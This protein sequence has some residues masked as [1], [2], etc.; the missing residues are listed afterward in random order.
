MQSISQPAPSYEIMHPSEMG[1]SEGAPN[2]GAILLEEITHRINNDIASTIAFIELTAARS[3]NEDVKLALAEVAQ[4]IHEFANVQR[5]LRVPNGNH[6][7]NA[8]EYLRRLCRSISLANLQYRDIELLFCETPVELGALSCWRMGMIVS[9]LITN[10]ARH[11]FIGR[12]GQI[13]VEL[14]CRSDRV[15][16]T[17]SDTGRASEDARPGHG[18]R[19]VSELAGDLRGR[20]HRVSGM[21][22]T[23]VRLSFPR[24]ELLEASP[25]SR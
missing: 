8:S 23:S 22:G 9:E 24:D 5:A 20:L 10:A 6:P 1:I 3:A 17:V 13:T 2:G 21:Q 18:S 14:S 16:C 11:A 4:H 19:I 12:G 25:R 7:I 15:E